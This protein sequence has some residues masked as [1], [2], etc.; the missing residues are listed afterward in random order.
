M[1]IKNITSQ[2]RR[3]F[4][5][6]YECEHCGS[7]ENKSGYDD[8]YFHQNVIPEMECSSCGKSAGDEYT[9][10]ATKYAEHEVV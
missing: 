1:N 8:S 7:V 6:D 5:A 4:Y 2:T 9:P 10:L 3:D